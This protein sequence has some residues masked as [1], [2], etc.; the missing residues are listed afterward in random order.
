MSLLFGWPRR[1]TWKGLGFR[2]GLNICIQAHT[3]SWLFKAGAH[4]SPVIPE[5]K[6][7][8]WG[9]VKAARLHVLQKQK[10]R[11]RQ[12]IGFDPGSLAAS[13]KWTWAKS[14]LMGTCGHV[15]WSMSRCSQ[16]SRCTKYPSGT[17]HRGSSAPDYCF[18]R[19]KHFSFWN[20]CWF[21]AQCPPT[22]FPGFGFQVSSPCQGIQ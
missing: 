10:G 4:K 22:E 16:E 17:D 14:T 2:K 3:L 8:W 20:I 15:S 13:L 1:S 7:P 9:W 19:H 18:C 5:E 12:R 11:K 21:S 6:P